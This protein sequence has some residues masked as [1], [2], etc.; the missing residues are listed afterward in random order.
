M[1]SEK[2]SAQ[3]GFTLLE[4]LVALAIVGIGMM[5]VFSQ[6]SQSLTITERLRS[7]TIAGWIALD[8]I[9]EL[10]VNREFPRAG[11]QTDELEIFGREWT[12]TVKTTQTAIEK[13]RRIDVSVSASETPEFVLSKVTGFLHNPTVERTEVT[14]SGWP[15]YNT[16]LSDGQK[17]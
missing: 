2:F 3:S 5:A 11:E 13:I 14:D 6:L 15:L 16:T 12:F 7:K 17:E 1:T 8:R 10:R 4:V 9:T